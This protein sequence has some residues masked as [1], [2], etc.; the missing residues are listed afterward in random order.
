MSL[1]SRFWSSRCHKPA[2]RLAMMLERILATEAVL[3]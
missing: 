3:P 2:L 1:C